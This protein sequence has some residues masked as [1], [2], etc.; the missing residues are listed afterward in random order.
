MPGIHNW[1]QDTGTILC[2]LY[3]VSKGNRW[4]HCFMVGTC[5][6][7]SFDFILPVTRHTWTSKEKFR[8]TLH[9]LFFVFPLHFWVY[10]TWFMACYLLSFDYQ[11]ILIIL[12]SYHFC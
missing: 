8:D 2:V 6:E 4:G 10:E 3:I 1:H 11:I 9:R 5:I 7:N 12:S